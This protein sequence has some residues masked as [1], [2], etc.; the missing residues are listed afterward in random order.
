M[1]RR[2]PNSVPV[3]IWWPENP[4]GKDVHVWHDFASKL[5]ETVVSFPCLATLTVYSFV[6]KWC[7]T[8]SHCSHFCENGQC[9]KSTC[10]RAQTILSASECPP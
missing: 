2:V 8:G 1:V 9:M 7:L 5:L 6:P 10:R 3:A 4:I